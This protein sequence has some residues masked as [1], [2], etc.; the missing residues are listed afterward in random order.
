MPWIVGQDA[1]LVMLGTGQ[2]DLEDMLRKFDREHHD[3]ARGRVG[4]SVKMAHR[5]TVGEVNHFCGESDRRRLVAF[6]G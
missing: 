3:K 6:D 5:I 2:A 1:Q 4:F